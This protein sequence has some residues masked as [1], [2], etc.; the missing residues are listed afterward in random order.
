MTE[1]LSLAKT[2]SMPGQTRLDVRIEAFN[3]FNRIIW[4]EPEQNF[5]SADFG[6]VTVHRDLAAPDAAWVEALLVTHTGDQ[7]IRRKY[8]LVF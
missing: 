6:R 1:N 7:E 4:G 5:N 8:L 2:I 3:I